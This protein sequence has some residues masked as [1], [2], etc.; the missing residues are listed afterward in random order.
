MVSPE[1]MYTEVTS[2]RPRGSHLGIY[3]YVFRYTD[4]HV[5]T[6]DRTKE[7]AMNPKGGKEEYL[8]WL[9]RRK[10]KGKMT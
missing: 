6:I 8:G 2:S 3:T 1:N 7:E 10:V 4:V 5:T 9:R